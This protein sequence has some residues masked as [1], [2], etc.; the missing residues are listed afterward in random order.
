MFSCKEGWQRHKDW[1]VVCGKASC[2][3]DVFSYGKYSHSINNANKNYQRT[4]DAKQL[5][6]LEA[7]IELT[8]KNPELIKPEKFKS[9]L[10][11]RRDIQ[12]EKSL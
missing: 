12:R 2:I 11:T 9:A 4:I 7:N 3:C 10:E 1:M 5:K 6:K 8:M